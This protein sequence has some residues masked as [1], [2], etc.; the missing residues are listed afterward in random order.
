VVSGAENQLRFLRE[1]GI[2]GARGELI[3]RA[4]AVLARQS[5]NP[6]VDTIPW[7]VRERIV[8]AMNRKGMS[9]RT[10]AAAIGEQY[11]GSYMLGSVSRQR[12]SSRERIATIARVVEDGELRALSESDVAWDTVMAIEPL[13]E[14]PVFDATVLGTHNFL[15]NNIVAHNSIEQDADVVIFIYRDVKYNP[16]TERPHVADII[17]AKHRNGPTGTV[18]LFFQDSLMR[19]LDLSVRDDD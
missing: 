15:A 19:F 2:Y 7:E 16:E 12:S 14:Q 1:I 11:P 5:P 3:E 17:V 6:N 13:G 9:Q 4:T 8:R 18:H 10:L